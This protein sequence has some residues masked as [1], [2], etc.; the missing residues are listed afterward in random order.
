MIQSNF[1]FINEEFYAAEVS[2]QHL[3][4]LLA[5]GWRHFGTFFFRYNI[6]IYQSELR[7]V[8]PLRINLANFS[9]SKSQ[10]KI[11]RKNRDLQIVIRPVEITEEKETL[12]AEHKQRF[13]NNIPDSLYA[14]LDFDA[15]FVPCKALEIC[16]Y[17]NEKLL[18]ASFFDVG[19]NSISSVY[20]IFEPSETTRSLGIF[21][22][23]LEIE[24]ALENAKE[25]YYQGYAYEGNS[26]YDYKKRFSGL[27]KYDWR[28]NWESFQE[29]KADF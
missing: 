14:F 17:E 25:F 24:Y 13:E 1:S 7:R 15:S 26:F 11:V 6:N 9:F 21:T 16:V 3:D 12:F 4:A 8:F 28:E 22:M 20:A 2:P 19:A 23:L 5:G 10:R 18:A 29:R 27:E